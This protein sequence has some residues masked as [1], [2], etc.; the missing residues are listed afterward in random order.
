MDEVAAKV[1]QMPEFQGL[2]A[3]K[4]ARITNRLE[5]EKAGL[6]TIALIPVLQNKA[7]HVRTSLL[8]EMIAEVDRLARPPQETFKPAPGVNDPVARAPLHPTTVLASQ[9]QFTA[10]KTRLADEADVDQYLVELKKTLLAEIHA[11][12]KVIV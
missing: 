6:D 1:A 9:L 10:P 12:K 3:D 7:N 8:A 4:Q 5:H 2:D 11:G